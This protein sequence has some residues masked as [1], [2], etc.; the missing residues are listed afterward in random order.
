MI[1]FRRFSE[2]F[3]CFT[4]YAKDLR[5]LALFKLQVFDWFFVVFED[6]FRFG[7]LNHIRSSDSMARRTHIASTKI[8]FSRFHTPTS[9]AYRRTCALPPVF[10]RFL[11]FLS[12]ILASIIKIKSNNFFSRNQS[13]WL[14]IRRFLQLLGNSSLIL[15]ILRMSL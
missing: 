15:L 4:G 11:I 6:F 2:V 8:T 7:K 9:L 12:L 14:R 3:D 1:E 5:F 10:N 13:L